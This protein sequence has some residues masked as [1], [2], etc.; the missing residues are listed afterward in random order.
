MDFAT[1]T[2]IA[3]ICILGAMSPGPSL[4]I[5]IRNTTA[6][7]QR[8]GVMAAV[9][10]AIGVGVYALAAVTGLVFL[11]KAEPALINIINWAGAG[12]LA[13]VGFQLTGIIPQKCKVKDKNRETQNS[14][15]F[16]E[17]FT[18]AFL[19]PKIAAFFVA[20]FSQFVH[21]DLIWFD[22]AI[23][24]LTAATID[25]AWYV[26]VALTV[27][28]S[29]LVDW[30]RRKEVFANRIIGSLLLIASIGLIL[31]AIHAAN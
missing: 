25:G 9:G 16:I 17:G 26:I 4:A 27:T 7:G 23:M 6:G 11:L 28:V 29:G 30:L 8:Q 24:V 31:R 14:R 13:W 15:G 21:P 20:V 3:L 12:F 5:I 19:N 22:R 10:H 2:K 18:V 1:W